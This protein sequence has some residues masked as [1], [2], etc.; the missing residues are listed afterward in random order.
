MNQAICVV[1]IQKL[2]AH[3]RINRTRV[4][5]LRSQIRA[6]GTVNKPI[7]VDKNSGVILDGHHRVRALKTLGAVKAP[8]LYVHYK[9]A[10]VRVYLRRKELLMDM[11]KQLVIARAVSRKPFPVKTTRHIIRSGR[12]R[13][14]IKLGDLMK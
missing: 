14:R 3:E 7:V 11:I 10:G 5:I 12:S 9:D 4:T 13:R 6:C 1:D 2:I 8:V